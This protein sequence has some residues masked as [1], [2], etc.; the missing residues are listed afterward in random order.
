MWRRPSGLVGGEAA[1]LP[2]A[3]PAP[4]RGQLGASAAGRRKLRAFRGVAGPLRAFFCEVCVES[5]L[6][7]Q[8]IVCPYW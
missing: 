7:F 1:G 8:E 4:R 3:G 5:C 6:H 2:Q